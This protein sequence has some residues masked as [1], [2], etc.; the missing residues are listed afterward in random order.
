MAQPRKT[1]TPRTG[2]RPGASGSREAILEA[3]RTLF[4]EHGYSATSM[5]AIGTAAGVDAALIVHF[6]GSKA[7][8][9][10]EAIEW[11]FDPVEAAERVYAKGRRN[12][13]EELARLVVETWEREGDRSAIMTLLRAATVEPS[14]AEMLREFMQ[15][16]L[17]PPLFQRLNPDQPDLRAGLATA[18]IV[19]LG[20]ARYVL[21]LEPLA[22]MTSDEVIAWVAPTLQ[23]YLTGKAP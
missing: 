17:A 5:R 10:R 4:A 3:A 1:R 21:R 20:M 13:G 7:R 14:A 12:V 11:P 22:S 16:E 15:D 9:L 6:F 23:R 18:Q 8:L 2:R 19:G